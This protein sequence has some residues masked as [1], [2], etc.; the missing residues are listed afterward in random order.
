[1][2]AY[3]LGWLIFTGVSR[4]GTYVIVFSLSIFSLLSILVGVVSTD[5]CAVL[6]IVAHTLISWTVSNVMVAA[7]QSVCLSHCDGIISVVTGVHTCCD[8]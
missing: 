7:V 1:M 8:W 2:G 4:D 6:M 3:W 5:S